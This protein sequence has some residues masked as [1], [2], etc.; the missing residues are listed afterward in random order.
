MVQFKRLREYLLKILSSPLSTMQVHFLETAM[1]RIPWVSFQR[2]YVTYTHT[3]KR[4]TSIDINMPYAGVPL[5]SY[6][7]C[8]SELPTFP[9]GVNS[10]ILRD[11]ACIR[12]AEWLPRC[13]RQQQQRSPRTESDR[14][15][16]QMRKSTVKLYF[17]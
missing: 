6:V 12:M 11:C 2:F 10:F 8:A 4:V 3:K 5:M 16:V 15:V 14:W 13:P 17:C 9:C 7:E 1:P